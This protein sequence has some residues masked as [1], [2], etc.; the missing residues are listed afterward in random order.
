MWTDGGPGQMAEPASI[1]SDP[2]RR[3]WAYLCLWRGRA[4]AP[5]RTNGI[6]LPN[7]SEP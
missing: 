1:L 6:S 4:C 5:S 7:G 3:A 2:P